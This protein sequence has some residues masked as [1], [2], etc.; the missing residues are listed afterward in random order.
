[1]DQQCKDAELIFMKLKHCQD[2]WIVKGKEMEVPKAAVEKEKLANTRQ[3]LEMFSDGE[4]G[5]F[6]CEQEVMQTAQCVWIRGNSL[7]SSL[8]FSPVSLSHSPVANRIPGMCRSWSCTCD[9]EDVGNHGCVSQDVS[10]CLQRPHA[11]SGGASF[12]T[13][14]NWHFYSLRF[15]LFLF[16]LIDHSDVTVSIVEAREALTQLCCLKKQKF[17]TA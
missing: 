7:L 9:S 14:R 2:S 12:S 5:F 15:V 1:M 4:P 3:K 13:V 8:P 16:K 10:A 6:Q 17:P 11:V